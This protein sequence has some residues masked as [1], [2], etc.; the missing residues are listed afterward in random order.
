MARFKFNS[1]KKDLPTWEG[2]EYRFL[3]NSDME[4]GMYPLRENL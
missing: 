3:E 4:N 1:R 2:D